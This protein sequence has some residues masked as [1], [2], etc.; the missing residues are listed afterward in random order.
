MRIAIRADASERIG[1]GHIR[2]DLALADALRARGAEVC[3]VSRRG[4]GD[5]HETITQANFDLHAL[6]DAEHDIF[7]VLAPV[8][9]II[10]DHYALS[11][12]WEQYA[13]RLARRV[14]VI[15]DLGRKHDCDLLLDQ[16]LGADPARYAGKV[17]EACRLLLGPRYALLRE[18]FRGYVDAPPNR[19]GRLRRVLV[20]MGGFDA[21]GETG[22]VLDALGTMRK[23]DFGVDV[24]L[25]ADAP[26]AREVE[27]RCAGA[28]HRYHGRVTKIAPL[29]EKADL[30]IGAM[31][32]TAWERC[33]LALPGIVITIAENQLAGALACANAGAAIWLGD[34]V[35]V[36]AEMIRETLESFAGDSERLLKM[37][38]NA[39]AAAGADDAIFSTDRAADAMMR[40]IDG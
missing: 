25:P 33:L 19:D 27:R 13:R 36:R 9:A 40:M 5:M 23:P 22:K 6:D 37:S 15:D 11:D 16:N 35:D 26:H 12:A 21:T 31:G 28:G 7:Q 4:K 14:F 17:P 32:A 24:V 39:R 38:K 30:A 1:S 18:E 10:I 34:A 20:S 3:F 8:D 29:M 2:R